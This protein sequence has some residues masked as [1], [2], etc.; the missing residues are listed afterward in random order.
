MTTTA[1]LREMRAVVAGVSELTG[2]SIGQVDSDVVMVAGLG[3]V[4]VTSIAAALDA[5][6]IKA[7]EWSGPDQVDRLDG[8]VHRKGGA[9]IALLIVD[10]SSGVGEP[11]VELL[12]ALTATAPIVALVCNKID[13]F[14]DWPTLLKA[15]RQLLDPHGRLPIFAVSAAAAV[16]GHHT[17]SGFE[18]LTGWLHEQL[19]P[20][21]RRERLATVAADRT[22]EAF[23]DD[24]ATVDPWLGPGR[25]IVG[26][27]GSARRDPRPRPD[28]PVGCV[29]RRCRPDP[30]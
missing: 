4:G 18:A 30:R 25:R 14:W 11:E 29:A 17:G 26:R 5:A 13:A 7:S 6:G 9:A 27:T 12:R 24:L 2:S 8:D 22:L 23:V 20:T 10:P 21:D 19:H 15:N 16:A 1:D 28:G 3:R